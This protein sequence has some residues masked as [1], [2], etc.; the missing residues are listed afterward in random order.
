M[1]PARRATRCLSAANILP[2]LVRRGV[3]PDIVTDQTSAHDPV[4][5]YLPQDWTLEQWEERIA[6]DPRGVAKAASESMA[7]HVRV[8]LDFHAMGVPAVDYGNNIRKVALD[9]GV[10]N[11]FVYTGFVP[12]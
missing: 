3:C 5:G 11:A 2:E 7:G 6:S 9:E 10:D 8:M 4:N 12:A 1:K